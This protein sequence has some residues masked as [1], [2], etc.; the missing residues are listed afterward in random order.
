MSDFRRNPLQGRHLG[1]IA[2]VSLVFAFVSAGFID[3]SNGAE[4]WADSR[5]SVTR[6]LEFWFDAR[7]ANGPH[8]TPADGKAA[9]WMDAS[10]QGRH[11][12]QAIADAR[13]A[14]L[15]VGTEAV[16]RFDGRDDFFH[17][18][19][20]PTERRNVTIFVVAS[21]RYNLGAFSGLLASNAANARDFVSGIALD[22]GPA[23]SARF[24]T[25]NVE[26]RGFSS[27]KNLMKPDRPFGTLTTLAVTM[28]EG[29]VRLEVDGQLTG[30]RPRD[31][32]PVSIAELTLGARFYEHG[33]GPQHVQGFGGWDIAEVLIYGRS[34]TP[35]ETGKV[36][37]YLRTRYESVK[38][39][40]P[41]DPDASAESLKPVADPPPVQVFLPGFEVR[42]LPLELTNVNNV[43]YR[44]DGSL[45]ALG[46]DGRIWSLRDTDGDGIEDTAELFWDSHGTLRSPIGMDVTPPGFTHGDG[47]AVASK[48]R[49]VLV[50]DTD[51]DGKGDKEIVIADGWKDKNHQIDAIGIAID[52]HDGSIFFGRGTADYTN[53]YLKDKD[54]KAHF[55]LTDEMGTIQRV[56]PDLKSRKIVATGIR[57]SVGLRFDRHGELFAT[58]Q[59]GATWLPNGNPLDELLHIRQGRHYGFPPRHP[60]HLPNVIDE[61]SVFDYPPQHQSLCGFAFDEPV[62]P[63]GRTFGPRTWTGD[64][65]VT[66]ESR[67]KLFRTR[68]VRTENGYVGQSS[69]IA[70]LNM[71]TI[72]CCI[73]PDGSLRIAC[74]SGGPDWGSGPTGKGKIYAVRYAEPQQPQPVFVWPNGPREVRVEFDQ[75]LEPENLGELQSGIRVTS[76][77]FVSA[78]DRF[79]SLWPGYAVVHAE[80]LVARKDVPVRGVS[81]SPDRRS[82]ILTTDPQTRPVRFALQLPGMGRPARDRTNPTS[83]VPEID[84]AWDLSGVEAEWTPASGKPS[85]KGWLPHAD[86]NVARALTTDSAPHQA[87]W[88]AMREPGE[89]RL[90]FRLDLRR[91]LQAAIQ[92][93]SRIDFDEPSETVTVRF[94]SSGSIR[95]EASVKHRS[96]PNSVEFSVDNHKTGMVEMELRAKFDSG[97]PRLAMNFSTG[98]DSNPRPLPLRRFLVPWAATGDDDKETPLVRPEIP[99]LAGGSW[100]RGRK[101]F[102]GESASCSKCHS[103]HGQ[104]GTIGPD[105]SNLRHRDYAS[106]LRDIVSPSYA[107]NPDHLSY[108]VELK[109]GQILT[110]TV[111]IEG[112]R[113]TVG[114]VEGKETIVTRAEIERLSPS[115]ASI[116]PE[117]L[118]QRIGPD[119]FRDLMS[120]LLT[121]GPVMPE[122]GPLKAPQPRR[123]SEVLAVLAGAPAPPPPARDLKVVLVSGPK[124]HGPGEHDYPAWQKAWQ[125]L[126]AIDGK[127]SVETANAWPAADQFRTADVLI[128]FQRGSWNADR[129]RE[130]DTFFARGGGAVYLHYAVDGGSDANGFADRIGLAWQ[131]GRSKFRHGPLDLSFSQDRK[132]PITRNFSKLRLYDESYWNLAGDPG[133]TTILAEGTEEGSP[134]PLIWTKEPGEGRVVVSIPGHFSWTFDDP[135]FRLLILR[136]IAW[137]AREPVDRF[138]A[139]VLPGARVD[140]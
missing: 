95:L 125:E 75:P 122:Y 123:L 135:L 3:Q 134:Q 114:N 62:V 41:P 63:G 19:G 136:G 40:L 28:D 24:G 44:H 99:E 86:L 31:G 128:F 67:G 124:D 12:K 70:A 103:V 127:L 89:L 27:W 137:S 106:V 14:V 84:L 83:Q 23:P 20:P 8:P 72:D 58:D 65:I 61:P 105:L 54:G 68:I 96:G 22:Q 5:M 57:F 77:K 55:S 98:D 21:P 52:P 29:E 73:A 42:E 69:L 108:S 32:Q 60:T 26:G 121:D 7:R 133:R 120:F 49:C 71:L 132:H 93:G 39:A 45:M 107:L 82:L 2:R 117:G 104:G 118:P 97:D 43:L 1:C 53:A 94:S 87:L 37:G 47:V 112:E 50:V 30:K 81:V 116:M 25:F 10:G 17:L 91:M 18:A 119:D 80:K 4:P 74:H 59:E 38:N 129:A 9:I 64:A 115:A 140:R 13:A 139:L 131:D 113:V 110:G 92:P 78:G 48:S 88:Q 66:G 100:A 33:P 109:T 51:K 76:G 36:H 85:W 90:K 35:E 56:T 126:L 130:L 102:F 101:V 15:K 16:V 46:Y 79:E 138:D 111:R 11:L 34:L 6:D